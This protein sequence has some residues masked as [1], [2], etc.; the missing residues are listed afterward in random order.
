MMHMKAGTVNPKQ[1]SRGR[2]PNNGGGKKHGGGGGM[3]GGGGMP[4][5]N[6]VFDSNGPECRIRGNAHQVLE[7]YLTLAR[8]ASLQGDRVAAENFYQHAEHYFR[9]INAQ[10]QN[11]G[12][13]RQQ[14]PT[15]AD[16]QS[17]Q[18]EDENGNEQNGDQG[19]DQG[20]DNGNGNEP[21]REQ[22]SEQNQNREARGHRD[23]RE[24]REYREPRE[25]REHREP[26]EPRE[27]REPRHQRQNFTPR[28]PVA[29]EIPGEGP[30]P[31]LD[32]P[33]PPVMAAPAPVAVQAPEPEAPAVAEAAPAPRAPRRRA[34]RAA[35]P[36]PEAV[37][38]PS[39]A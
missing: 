20:Y 32:L 3:S 31:V 37:P 27:N 14:M 28:P 10:N 39:E 8:D 26:R 5:P 25:P 2:G 6:Q 22:R 36:A 11:N 34:P 24:P 15:P 29:A 7:K 19:G 17:M 21:S 18:S 35:A 1:R 30:Q 13:P 23:Q 4:R 12:R 38:E 33:L 16:E 9:V